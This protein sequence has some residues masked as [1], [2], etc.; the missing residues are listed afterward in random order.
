MLRNSLTS[1]IVCALILGVFL[2]GTMT[3][4][5]KPPTQAMVKAEKALDDARKKE[6]DIY[7]P[8]TYILAQESF[9]KAKKLIG[10]KDYQEAKKAAEKTVNLA[11]ES[12]ALVDPGKRKMKEE[13]NSI[14]RQIEVEMKIFKILAAKAVRKKVYSTREALESAIGKSEIDI[15]NVKEKLEREKIKDVK[16]AAS[17]ILA[18]VKQR[19]LDVHAALTGKGKGRK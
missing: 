1:Y 3:G 7:A 12:V 13:T 10:M 16:D 19:N 4:C 2:L 11:G 9:E 17:L 8:E 15:E 5:T 18:Q 14:L 6:A